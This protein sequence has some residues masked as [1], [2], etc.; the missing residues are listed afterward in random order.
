MAM[1]HGLGGLVQGNTYSGTF[2]GAVLFA[3]TTTFNE[4]YTSFSGATMYAINVGNL[5][6]VNEATLA[7]Y[8]KTDKPTGFPGST[9]Y[10]VKLRRHRLV[11]QRRGNQRD[12]RDVCRRAA[13]GHF[14][15]HHPDRRRDG[16][17]DY[18]AI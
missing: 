17:H 8:A 5:A 14:E 1:P 16:S 18:H 2:A 13:A 7:K 11:G 15:E 9:G 4:A 6:T 12:C 10:F 3:G